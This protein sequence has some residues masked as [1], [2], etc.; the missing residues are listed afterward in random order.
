[1]FCDARRSAIGPARRMLRRA[2]AI[3]RWR[4]DLPTLNSFSVP[5]GINGSF[6]IKDFYNEIFCC[7]RGG[8]KS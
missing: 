6:S 3:F 1:M 4:Y 8:Y 7:F 2:A 5:E